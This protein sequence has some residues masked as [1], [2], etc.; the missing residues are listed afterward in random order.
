[1]LL[2]LATLGVTYYFVKQMPYNFWIFLPANIAA[3][4]SLLFWIKAPARKKARW[5]AA[6]ASLLVVPC[7]AATSVLGFL[8]SPVE[9]WVTFAAL[10]GLSVIIATW[11]IIRVQRKANHMWSDYYAKI[12]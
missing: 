7:I 2:A 3:T 6:I 12:A 9:M 1:M 10:C 4:G 8:F 11:A 5:R